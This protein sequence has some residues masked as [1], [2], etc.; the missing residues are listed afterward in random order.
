L[1]AEWDRALEV[2]RGFLHH[3]PH[4]P[5]L[6][7][8]VELAVDAGRDDVMHEAQAQLADAYLA[9]GRGTEARVIAE[10]L[11]ARDPSSEVH[12]DRLRRALA[13][14][15]VEDADAII[16]RYRDAGTAF[17]ES[18]D[19]DLS[20]PEISS[21][22]DAERPAPAAREAVEEPQMDESADLSGPIATS[23]R[24]PGQPDEEPLS[25]D[26]AA[27]TGDDSIVLEVLEIDL[28]D[29]LAG[30][31]GTS[32]ELP[33]PPV[34]PSEDPVAAP[35]DLE[36]VF[37]AMRTRVTND[38]AG[39]A[40]ERYE[41]ALEHLEH[42]RTAEAL[43]D[44]QSAA[45]A[46]QFRFRAAARLGR[47]FVAGG[48]V[49]EGINWLERAAEAPAPSPEESVSVLYDLAGAL[50][51]SGETARALAILMEI[52]TDAGN[53]RD[54]RHRIEQLTRAQAGSPRP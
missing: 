24:A 40:A 23:M 36:S 45:R 29:A 54:V 27:A 8:L 50:E 33:P 1:A 13:L 38:Q 43:G 17:G 15:G 46:P 16:D 7:K 19:F 21:P 34:V 44:L 42:G 32:P 18:L 12:V 39:D 11:V 53:Y 3:G 31:G 47:L 5:A 25:G 49:G 52:D 9:Q 2:L 30:L 14:V 6:V 48:D 4:I 20:L 37:E 28:S 10:D 26:D 51:R 35:R 41:R 22:A